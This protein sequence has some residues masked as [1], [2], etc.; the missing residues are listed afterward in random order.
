MN[1]QAARS[2]V[3]NIKMIRH[4]ANGGF[5]E[6]NHGG[7]G[8]NADWRPFTRAGVYVNLLDRY[9]PAPSGYTGV[10]GIMVP[11][12]LSVPGGSGR[13]RHKTAFMKGLAEL[14]NIPPYKY[15]K[16]EHAPEVVVAICVWLKQMGVYSNTTNTKDIWRELDKARTKKGLST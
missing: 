7:K 11:P 5:L 15:E 8:V 12:N 6:Y 4:Y 1:R 16:F 3:V 9:R 10:Q 2:I 14:N 13:S